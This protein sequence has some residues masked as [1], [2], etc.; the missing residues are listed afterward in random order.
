MRFKAHLVAAA[1]AAALWSGPAAAGPLDDA[2]RLFA[3]GDF[4]TAAAL[5][6]ELDSTAGLT[7]AAG[8]TL[9]HMDFVAAP[10][11][12]GEV[13]WQAEQFARRALARNGDRVEALLY[14]SIAVSAVAR[15]KGAVA[16]HF[17]GLADE[18]RGYLERAVALDPENPWSHG[19]L[20]AWHLEIIRHAGESL[21]ELFYDASLE[22][23]LS[24]FAR[25]F[26]LDPDNLLLHGEFAI[27]LLALDPRRYA[28]RAGGHLR[29][30]LASTPVNRLE[31]LARE[32]A[33]G[34]LA[35]LESGDWEAL[36]RAVERI[37][38]APLAANDLR[39]GPDDSR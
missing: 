25:A 17:E 8:A 20:G 18:G 37:R 36:A 39:T 29:K 38:G 1:L 32:R 14:L 4:L 9:A 10:E 22:R 34:T 35:S 11:A 13:A 15:E 28:E 16:A 23:G 19:M 33:A 31:H 2:E 30:V 7:L 24:G 5:A 21:A 12:R 27:S 6:A 26:E 3:E